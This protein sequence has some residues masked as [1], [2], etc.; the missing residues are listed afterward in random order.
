MSVLF[1]K[2]I[3]YIAVTGSRVK[4]KWSGSETPGTFTGNVQPLTGR[5]LDVVQVGRKDI[6]KVKVYA[7]QSLNVSVE[8]SNTPGDIIIWQG[9][10]W[11][12][13]AKLPYQNDLI[14]HYKYIAEFRETYTP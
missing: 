8:G 6:G 2:T 10:R 1:P 12:I 9:G 13:I 14:N 4:G 7:N 5:E 3:N 11:E